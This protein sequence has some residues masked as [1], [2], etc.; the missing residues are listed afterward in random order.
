METTTLDLTPQTANVARLVAGVRDDQLADP[1]PCEG[2]SVAGMLDHLVGL[3]VAFAMGARKE[4]VS[5]SPRAAADQLP[6]DWRD[7]LPL[8]LAELA[9]AWRQPDAWEGTT[10]VAGAE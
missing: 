5:G 9:Q 3:T 4:P 8:Q 6:P 10:T 7:R 1:T 2:T